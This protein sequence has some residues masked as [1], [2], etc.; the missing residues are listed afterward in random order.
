MML[1][2]GHINEWQI[3]RTSTG[4]AGANKQSPNIHNS[5][6]VN[7]KLTFHEIICSVMIFLFSI[8]SYKWY[9]TTRVNDTSGFVLIK[10]EETQFSLFLEGSARFGVDILT[11]CM[12]NHE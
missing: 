2:I 8:Q 12:E 10:M 11:I 3:R 9:P 1:N 7:D 6:G 5:V 4:R